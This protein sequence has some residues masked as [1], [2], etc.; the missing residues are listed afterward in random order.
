MLKT[1]MQAARDA[2][3]LKLL[4]ETAEALA[5]AEGQ[6]EPAAEHFVLAALELAD[7]AAGRVFTRLGLDGAGF[8]S[9]LVEEQREALRQVGVGEMIIE[10]TIGKGTPLPPPSGLYE[11]APSGKVVVQELAR[12]RQRGVISPLDG[13]QV[14]KVVGE[15]GQ[16]RA[17]RALRQMGAD[18]AALIA[19][20]DA[21]IAEAA[22][23]A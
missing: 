20:A 1:M 3:T 9:A 7:G 11:A 14:L 4:C 19:A 12:L 10:Q 17:V 8:R 15:M 23:R 18:P 21:E 22:A 16:G 6:P 2:G 13:A 5:R